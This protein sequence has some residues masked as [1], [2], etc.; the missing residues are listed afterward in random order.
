[1]LLET[2]DDEKG[3]DFCGELPFSQ[4]RSFISARMRVHM[5]ACAVGE[6]EIRSVTVEGKIE[7]SQRSANLW[8]KKWDDEQ[9]SAEA[10][11]A[12]ARISPRKRNAESRANSPTSFA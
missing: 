12:N 9:L 3:R 5:H 2:Y 1:M 8:K 4:I 6:E 11:R 7:V 10:Q